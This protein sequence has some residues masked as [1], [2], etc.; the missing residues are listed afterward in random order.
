MELNNAYTFVL[1][2]MG[3]RRILVLTNLECRKASMYVNKLF[4]PV[5]V[6]IVVVVEVVVVVVVVVVV[7]VALKLNQLNV[8]YSHYLHK[9]IISD[10]SF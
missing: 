10:S 7:L 2:N 9:L 1:F 8:N 3:L 5:V 6:G 4:L